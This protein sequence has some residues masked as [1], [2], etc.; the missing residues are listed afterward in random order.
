MAFTTMSDAFSRPE[1][2]CSHLVF[3]KLISHLTSKQVS[4]NEMILIVKNNK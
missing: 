1:M 4:S 2:Y 3:S